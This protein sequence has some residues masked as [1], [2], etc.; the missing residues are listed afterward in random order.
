M[1]RKMALAAAL[2]ASLALAGGSAIAE[3]LEFD[4][5]G[6][7]LNWAVPGVSGLPVP[8]GADLQFGL[9]VADIA[10][11]PLTLVARI[12]GGW[13]DGR[14][15]RNAL[16]GDPCNEPGKFDGVYRYYMPNF[17]WA[18]GATQGLIQK[19]KGN[20][21]EAFAFYRG[22]YDVYQSSLGTGVFED[23][24]GIN[25]TSFLA[26]AAYD[27]TASDSRRV[28]TGAFAEASF[29]YGPGALNT[30]AGGKALDFWRVDLKAKGFYPLMSEGQASN[31]G[32]NLFS[33]YLA[34]FGSV[35]YAGGKNVPIWVMQSF[36]GRDLRGS[37]GDCV[38]GYP[39]NSYDSAFKAVANGELRALLP[40]LA[41]QAW[42]VPMAYAFCDLG[43]YGG[44]AGASSS[45]K[46]ASGFIAS[47]GAGINFNLLDFVNV[48]AYAGWKVPAGS[49]LYAVYTAEGNFFWNF[50]FLLHF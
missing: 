10:G 41:G 21:V 38:R 37:L 44:F 15:L 33:L 35:D 24:G 8:T 19:D 12:K 13:E 20:L 23:M 4:F 6:I 14:I 36:G 25:G 50:Q 2:A 40:A 45:W 3:G 32:L 39:S 9:P 30:G 11:Q 7:A 17:Q 29:E 48:G 49:N 5:K 27:S 31:D 43:Y 1:K 26:G 28:K 42:L 47:T 34:G 16:T 22:R 18:L 46:D